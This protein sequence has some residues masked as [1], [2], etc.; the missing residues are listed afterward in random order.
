[1]TRAKNG[2]AAAEIQLSHDFGSNLFERLQ[3]SKLRLLL[4][5]LYPERRIEQRGA[6]TLLMNCV[7][8]THPDRRPSFYI[9]TNINYAVC[10]SCGYR[11]RNLLEMLSSS[12]GLSF[13]ESLLRIQEVTGQRFASEKISKQLEALDLHQQA[14]RYFADACNQHLLNL[15]SYAHYGN[16]TP[17]EDSAYYNDALFH[18][19]KPVLDW[20]FVTRKLSPD[21][22][23]YLPYGVMPSHDIFRSLTRRLIEQDWDRQLRQGLLPSRYS[24]DRKESLQKKLVALH[25]EVP[26]EYLNSVTF[27]TGYTPNVAGRI[28]CRKVARD[29][30]TDNNFWMLPGFGPNDPVGYLGLWS[31]KLRPL[32]RAEIEK[33]KLKLVESEMSMLTAQ[34]RVIEHSIP[35]VMFVASAG[36]NNETDM[37]YHAGFPNV[38][39]LMDHPDPAYGRGEDQIKIRLNTAFMTQARVFTGWEAF[40]GDA[41]NVKDPDDALQQFGWEHFR[42]HVLD[43][44]ATTFLPADA[45]ASERAIEEGLTVPDG[46]ILK[47]QAKAV[48]FGLCVRHPALLAAF[49]TRVSAALNIP[50]GPLRAAIVQ[51]KDDE[52]GFIARIVETFKSDFVVLYKDDSFRVGTLVLFHKRERRYVTLNVTDGPGMLAALANIYGEMFTFFSEHIGLHQRLEGDERAGGRIQIREGQKYLSDYLKIAFQQIYQGVLTREECKPINA[53]IFCEDDPDD[54]NLMIARIH[55]GS[56]WYRCVIDRTTDQVKATE[57]EGPIDGRYIFQP[58]QPTWSEAITSV[59]A[60]E[61]SNQISVEDLQTIFQRIVYLLNAGWSFKTQEPDILFLAALVFVFAAGDAF[62]MKIILRLIGESNSGKSTAASLYCRGQWP[63]LQLVELASYSTGY[64]NASLYLQFSH[65]TLAMV[66]EEAS[67]DPSV[68][69]HKTKQLEDIQEMLRQVIFE[70]GAAIKR[71]G[72]NG[73]LVEYRVRTNV[74]MTAVQEPRDVQD[75]NRSYVVETVRDDTRRDPVITLSRICGE[76]EMRQMRHDI[77]I[78]V[79]RLLAKFRTNQD[80][81]YRYLNENQVGTYQAPTRFLRNFASVGGVIKT[82]GMD[83]K[84]MISM[85]VESRKNRVLSQAANSTSGLIYDRILRAGIIPLPTA[86][87]TYLSVM[88]ALTAPNGYELLNSAGV[89][90]VVNPNNWTLIVDFVAATSGPNGA[91]YRMNDFNRMTPHQLK[92]LLDQHP[93]VLRSH[94]YAD[95][96][97]MEALAANNITA[98]DHEITVLQ[99]ARLRE[100]VMRRAQ[101]YTGVPMTK[102]DA[103]GSNDSLINS[104]GSANN[105]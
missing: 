63:F 35:D 23:A 103:S 64:T 12:L 42:K 30:G 13:G 22:V 45:W 39:L 101:A 84:A 9:Y 3:V 2:G 102:T 87:G 80:A 38:D 72:M 91:L 92:A 5:Q 62:T 104:G 70:G 88:Q 83:W 93:D 51:V 60:I 49:V 6:S 85:M 86:R 57:L 68:N 32:Y 14:T 16:P 56:R 105:I 66:L 19:V 26:V 55:N 44:E 67:Q 100:Q 15:V 73:K 36:S 50:Q 90:I 65:S 95:Y 20:L 71:Y 33:F 48:D 61:R 74:V 28:R 29:T 77:Q 41:L 40:R 79:L 7:N 34:E 52:A 75:A 21:K 58:D 97:V 27:H 69:T 59:E 82:L 94:R 76:N 25:K 10:K 4:E 89:G 18:L 96:G 78:G 31:P 98:L 81:I 24:M 43:D 37:L 99:I 46:D 1:M 11:T 8:P 17:T 54:P 53:G 47:R